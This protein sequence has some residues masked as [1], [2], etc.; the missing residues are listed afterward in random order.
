MSILIKYGKS[1]L[2]TLLEII[3]LTILFS[4]IYYFEWISTPTFQILK[5]LSF[6]LCLFYNSFL[7]G[8]VCSKRGYLEGLKLG[9]LLLLFIF[10][11]CFS[12]DKIHF[13]LL[14]YNTIILSTTV[15]GSMVGIAKKKNL[16]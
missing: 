12:F 5:L 3:L 9:G 15:L 16:T 10:I 7:L 11:I 14:L 6:L 2:L 13:S 8:R 1:F 4:T